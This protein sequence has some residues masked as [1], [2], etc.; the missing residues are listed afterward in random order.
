MD[1]NTNEQGLKRKKYGIFGSFFPP[2]YD[3]EAMLVE[4]AERTLAGMEAFTRWMNEDTLTSPD[5]LIQ[6]GREVDL[7][8]YNLEA[9]LLE[10]FSTPF[11]RQDIY[12]FSRNM[13]YILNHAVETAREM[14]AFG[15]IPDEPIREMSQSLLHG[16]RHVLEGTRYLGTD[17]GR[18]EDSI[19]KGRKHVHAIEDIYI[20]C[21]ADLFQTNDAMEAMKKREIYYHLRGGGKA[22]RMT[23]Y[24]MHKAVVGLA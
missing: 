13:D 3:F 22:L 10:A 8:R 2:K 16:T 9:R 20:T 24:I 17:K 15:V 1:E 11:N 5:A 19:R 6:I 4:Q 7:H 14:H 21:M 23:L 12:T 18:V